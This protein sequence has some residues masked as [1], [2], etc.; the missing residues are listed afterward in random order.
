MDIDYMTDEALALL[1]QMIAIPSISREE[2]AVADLLAGFIE[3]N[4]MECYLSLIHI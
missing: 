4:G 2:E 1:K 3:E